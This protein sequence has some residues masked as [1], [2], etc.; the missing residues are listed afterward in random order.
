[1]LCFSFNKKKKT[2][3]TKVQVNDKIIVEAIV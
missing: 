2:G 3:L 1:M